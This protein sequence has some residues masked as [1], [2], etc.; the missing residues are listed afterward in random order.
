ME[1]YR[2][3]IFLDFVAFPDSLNVDIKMKIEWLSVAN[4][5]KNSDRDLINEGLSDPPVD[6]IGW[7]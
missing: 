4:L 5:N 1:K 7:K 2:D 3:D 6:V